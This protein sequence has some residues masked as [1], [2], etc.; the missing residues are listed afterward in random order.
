MTRID[1]VKLLEL[2]VYLEK[3]YVFTIDKLAEVLNCSVP[4]ARLKLKQWG[5]HTSYNKNGRYY[6]MP[7]TPHFDVNG[8]WRYEDIFFSKYGSL[9]KTVISLVG[10]SENGLTGAQIGE[11]V[12]LS[13]RSFLHHFRDAP[14]IF[15]EKHGGVYVY[16][17]SAEEVYHSQKQRLLEV[18][19]EKT[20][21]A[22]E[23]ITILTALIKHHNFS[24][25]FLADLPDVKRKK[26]SRAAIDRFMKQH[27]FLKKTT[28]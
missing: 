28:D 9:K 4:T 17:S 20:L 25:D 15:R 11:I 24:S 6:A 14:G 5:A 3:I 19:M 2:I 23:V 13:P 8:L 22:A 7:N 10:K 21:S 1:Q 16:F 12:G 26:I 18:K 27:G